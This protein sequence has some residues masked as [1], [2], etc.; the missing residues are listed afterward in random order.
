M[1][2]LTRV[3]ILWFTIY[4]LSV[5]PTDEK[6]Q[7]PLCRGLHYYRQLVL[8]PFVLPPIKLALSHPSIAPYVERATPYANQFVT[9][10]K[11]I[12]TR[13]RAEWNARVVPQW[14]KRV[15][16][17][18]NAHV[19]PQ[20]DKYGAPQITRMEQ[21]IEPYR[22]KAVQEYER[23]LGPHLRLAVYNLQK[24]Q[25]QAQ[26]YI[27]L[28]ANKTYDGYQ[29]SKPYTI[30]VLQRLRGLFAHLARFLVAQRRQYV[31]PHVKT[32]WDRVIE[33]SSG[34]SRPLTD[35]REAATRDSQFVSYPSPTEQ[36]TPLFFIFPNTI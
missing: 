33:L 25:R 11:P 5:C 19:V 27:I 12:I 29:K 22:L 10:A 34:K 35:S 18:W 21:Q 23:R 32:I 24:W 8:E 30:P 16:P 17:L 9:T 13:T 20:W 6:L 28:V 3:F 4:T 36:G 26:P 2:L 14:N 1:D 15:V 7:S 31:D